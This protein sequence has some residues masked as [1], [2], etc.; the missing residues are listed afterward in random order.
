M[1]PFAALLAPLLVLLPTASMPDADVSVADG[2]ERDPEG[3][4]FT[5][6]GPFNPF[7]FSSA[8]PASFREVGDS[9]RPEEADQVRIEQRLIVR[10][11]PRSSQVPDVQR[12][13]LMD[14]P[15]RSIGPQFEERHM[16]KCLSAA[17]IAGVQVSRENKLILFMRDHR[18]VS[19]ALEK[20]CSA[21]DF[22]SGFYVE[23][24][25]DGM[26]C[27]GRDKL[28]SRAGANCTLTRLRQLVEIDE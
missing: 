22:Y 19:A 5:V 23:R 12:N 27:A 17:G 18:I 8:A 6:E 28:Q 10:V 3:T 24:S 4:E 2:N 26:I 7:Y 25:D 21:R 14:I 1:N 11:A 20:A 16:G 13:M 15:N 9:F